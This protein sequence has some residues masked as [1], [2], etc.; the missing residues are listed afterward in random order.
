[1][2]QTKLA[3]FTSVF[4]ATLVIGVRGTNA[5]LP[6]SSFAGT[7]SGQDS[8]TFALC[9]NADYSQT[10]DCS[11][12]AHTVFY[13]QVSVSQGTVDT[14]G[15]SCSVDY[16]SSSPEFPFPPFPAITQTQI[17]IVN[18]TSYNVTT[19]TAHQSYAGYDAADGAS[20]NGSVLVNPSNAP[21]I[22][23][24]TQT[25]VASLKGTRVDVITDT[26]VASPVSDIDNVVLRG[27][28]F[29]Q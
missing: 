9:F 20:C 11:V 8:G 29:K 2:K 3:I 27:V 25:G 13:S 17:V 16:I 28:A 14:K 10:V 7:Y 12:A 6:L 18:T 4:A 22:T 23:S 19:E 26:L 24:G 1:V 5:G 15:N 21:A